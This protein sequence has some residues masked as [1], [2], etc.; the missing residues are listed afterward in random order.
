ME[1]S[2]FL[3]D[4]NGVFAIQPDRTT[5]VKPFLGKDSTRLS[6]GLSNPLLR[7]QASIIGKK[8]KKTVSVTSA[9]D[10][11]L[12]LYLETQYI[13]PHVLIPPLLV[14]LSQSDSFTDHSVWRSAIRLVNGADNWVSI[15]MLCLEFLGRFPV[16]QEPF[17]S[18]VHRWKSSTS[19]YLQR[20]SIV[21]FCRAVRKLPAAVPI[22]LSVTAHHLLSR[23]NLIRKSVA[24]IC[25]ESSKS[26][27]EVVY[28]WLQNHYSD[29]LWGTLNDAMSK[30]SSLQKTQLSKL[31]RG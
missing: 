6:Y 31:K 9:I 20:I 17:L 25:K 10:A 21:I 27:K 4:V 1:L 23:H 29:I 18:D 16:Y 8:F 19:V 24:W 14:A 30:L 15:D 2:D 11:L 22:A 13:E 7:K 26:D 3:N 5:D 12:Q 28:K